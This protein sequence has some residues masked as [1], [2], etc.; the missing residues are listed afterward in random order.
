MKETQSPVSR[1]ADPEHLSGAV[2]AQNKA[3]PLVDVL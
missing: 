3:M 1:C 2:I